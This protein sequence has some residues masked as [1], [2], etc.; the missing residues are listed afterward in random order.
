MGQ[1]ATAF[2]QGTELWFYCYFLTHVLITSKG[3]SMAGEKPGLCALGKPGTPGTGGY[4][5]NPSYL[6]GKD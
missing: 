4:T 2:P 1:H 3:P 6:G 5:Y